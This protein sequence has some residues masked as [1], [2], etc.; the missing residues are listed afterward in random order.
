M[1]K[2]ALLEAI[3]TAAATELSLLASQI[4]TYAESWKTHHDEVKKV[5]WPFEDHLAIGV[6]LFKMIGEQEETWRA[7]VFRGVQDFDPGFDEG[8]QLIYRYWLQP[9]SEIT[10]QLEQLERTYGS[11]RHAHEFR[12]ASQT[13]Q[14][15]LR[16]WQPPVLSSAIGLREV[17]LNEQASAEIKGMLARAKTRGPKAIEIIPSED[18]S[19]LRKQA[20]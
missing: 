4:E 19:F 15:S 3:M 18:L 8:F 12:A 6:S 16:S 13:V 20:K 5:L 17:T 10:Q 1:P 11:V 9:C 2:Q 7:R 14:D